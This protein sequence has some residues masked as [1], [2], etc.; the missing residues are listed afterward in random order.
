MPHRAPA[1]R[2]GSRSRHSGLVHLL[3]SGALWAAAG[4]AWAGV[5]LTLKPPPDP[6][7]AGAVYLLEP[8]LTGA[9]PGHPCLGTVWLEGQVVARAEGPS[10]AFQ[11]SAGT[12]RVQA[13]SKLDTFAIDE[14]TIR[15]LA[16]GQGPAATFSPDAPGCLSAQPSQAGAGF[17]SY[18]PSGETRLTAGATPQGPAAGAFTLAAAP[19][20]HHFWTLLSDTNLH[21]TAM[22]WDPTTATLVLLDQPG[23]GQTGR[24]VRLELNGLRTV[25]RM[26]HDPF[27]DGEIAF[28]RFQ[29]SP[30]SGLAGGRCCSPPPRTTPWWCAKPLAVRCAGSP[31]KAA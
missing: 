25:L 28:D 5:T 27:P 8:R 19:E 12:Y 30:D 31:W 20:A 7:A 3:V 22:A 29:F 23:Y 13:A 26:E 15:V 10:Y 24:V 2:P 21:P 1:S 6:L 11:R 14:T 9:D 16:E 18:D 17:A 4:A